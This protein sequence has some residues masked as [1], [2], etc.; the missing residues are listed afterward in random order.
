MKLEFRNQG[1]FLFYILGLII[2]LGSSTLPQGHVESNNSDSSISRAINA[3]TIETNSDEWIAFIGL[4]NNIWLI[5]LDGSGKRQI[6]SNAGEAG[7]YSRIK[8]SPD[9][10]LLA[11]IFHNQKKNSYQLMIFELNG[12]KERIIYGQ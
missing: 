2:L 9:G 12:E 7:S 4:D 1:L 11:Y 10:K 3:P 6:T 5:Y 8:W